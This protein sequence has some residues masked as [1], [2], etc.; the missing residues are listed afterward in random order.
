MKIDGRSSSNHPE[1][2]LSR[3]AGEIAYTSKR[4]CIRRSDEFVKQQLAS[5]AGCVEAALIHI[6]ENLKRESE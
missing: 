4:L 3:L 5:A 1:G 6:E 2:V